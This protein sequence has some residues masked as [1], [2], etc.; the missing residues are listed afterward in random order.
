MLVKGLSVVDR[1]ER[2]WGE[3]GW[4][5]RF[6]FEGPHR[7]RV[8]L[9]ILAYYKAFGPCIFGSLAPLQSIA[10]FDRRINIPC[11]SGSTSMIRTSISPEEKMFG[12]SC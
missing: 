10:C 1:L 9:R 11:A 6:A 4:R 8:N 2:M 3:E 5:T 12:E 7:P